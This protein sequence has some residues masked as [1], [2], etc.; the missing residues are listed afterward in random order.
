MAVYFFTLHSYRSWN[1]DNPRGFVKHDQGI[2]SPDTDRA[3][4]YDSQA[5]QEPILFRESHKDVIFWIAA[6]ACARRKW[7]LH[8]IAV[9]PTHV[10]I[11]VSWHGFQEWQAVR[12][13]LKN[14]M[15]L[16]L[17]RYFQNR[18]RSWFS[19]EGSRK[20]VRDRRHFEH[21]MNAYLPKHRWHWREG[22]PLPIKPEPRTSVRG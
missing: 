5:L 22:K 12:A 20:R 10:H 15:S 8:G 11:L 7:R 13:K 18:G 14:L 4:F 16:E 3:A 21:L 9:E 6:D 2:Q 1:A 19:R 17:G